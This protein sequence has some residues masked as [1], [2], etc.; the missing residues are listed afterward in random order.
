MTARASWL[1]S[2]RRYNNY[3]YPNFV[4]IAQW[5]DGGTTTRYLAAYRQFY[6]TNRDRN[7]GQLS[8]AVDLLPRLTVTPTV[9][10]R[11]DDFNLNPLTELGMN[12]DH[13][14]NAGVEVAYLV[15]PGTNFLFSY[16]YEDHRQLITSTNSTATPFA[17]A[18]YY[19]ADVRDQVNTFIVAVNHE[20]IPNKLDV[21]LG[22]TFSFARNS[23][24]LFFAS[25]AGPGSGGQFTD[26]T[27][28][29]HRLEALAR[30]KFDEALVQRLGWK[31]NVTAKLRYVWERNDVTNWQ[32]D[33][34]QTY[35]YAS[36]TSAGYMNWMAYNN[37]N[38][39]V[40]LIMAALA[41]AW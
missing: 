22:Y 8:L 7:K 41:F 10:W 32:I 34:M 15:A 3:D 35:M 13:S 25:G 4:G 31:G 29:F 6:L 21:R 1:Y 30:Y 39:N 2:L 40:H 33:N 37:P 36:D 16:M 23:Q 17:A 12:K 24:P 38:Y 20:L 27:T 28:M 19:S 9:G 14:W 11:Y 5:P 26:V 18:N